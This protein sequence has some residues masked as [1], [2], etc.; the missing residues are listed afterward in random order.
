MSWPEYLLQFLP[1]VFAIYLVL[2]SK[3]AG[4]LIT[5]RIKSFISIN[6][7]KELKD[8]M[9]LIQNFVLSGILQIILF[10]SIFA[11][12][13]AILV[14]LRNNHYLAFLAILLILVILIAF[15]YLI[16]ALD[17]DDLA[18]KKFQ[19]VGS[20]TMKYASACKIV[21][22]IVNMILCVAIWWSNKSQ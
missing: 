9:S 20:W 21:L 8:K 5:N 6:P 19:L 16:L 18:N 3:L 10:N 11:A 12:M 17:P 13:V 14:I 2:T 15:I 22:L 1:P 7:S 4:K